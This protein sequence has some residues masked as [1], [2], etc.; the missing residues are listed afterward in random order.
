[1]LSACCIDFWIAKD[2]CLVAQNSFWYKMIFFSKDLIVMWRNILIWPCMYTYPLVSSSVLQDKSTV[3]NDKIMAN[4]P[5]AFRHKEP[6]W[7]KSNKKESI[8]T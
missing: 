1:M 6:P 4:I 5:N 3:E 2:P 8:H 7:K